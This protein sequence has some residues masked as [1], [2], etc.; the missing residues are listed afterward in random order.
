MGR[1]SLGEWV[2]P[3]SL[4][5]WR[6]SKS[7]GRAV[8]SVHFWSLHFLCCRKRISFT[9]ISSVLFLT[10]F[11]LR[12]IVKLQNFRLSCEEDY[13]LQHV[14]AL[15]FATS[16]MCLQLFVSSRL[17]RSLCKSKEVNKENLSWKY[18]M[19]DKQNSATCVL[20]LKTKFFWPPSQR[21]SW[22]HRPLNFILTSLPA[23]TW[24]RLEFVSL[25]FFSLFPLSQSVLVIPL[26]CVN[27]LA[28]LLKQSFVQHNRHVLHHQ[29]LAVRDTNA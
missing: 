13:L 3:A 19:T 21:D 1:S 9:V 18:E 28:V 2:V 20:G 25:S 23:P 12:Y 15:Y 22:C 29:L 11:I 4:R 17:V 14:A 8:D 6:M 7:G 26:Y 10:C 5:P 16:P 24:F 27:L